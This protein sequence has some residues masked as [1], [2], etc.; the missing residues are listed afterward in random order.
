MIII[1]LL[2]INNLL[3]I[4]KNKNKVK[5]NIKNNIEK[6]TNLEDNDYSIKTNKL[7]LKNENNIIANI[8]NNKIYLGGDN[9]NNSPLYIEDGKTYANKLHVSKSS[10][11]SPNKNLFFSL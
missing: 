10:K 8:D 9:N 5:K 11:T 2:L 7:K 3:K 4:K 6:L 1:I